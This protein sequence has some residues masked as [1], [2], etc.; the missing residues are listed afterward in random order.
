[1]TKSTILR[2]SGSKAKLLT[3]LTALAPTQFNRYVEPFAGSA[4]VFFALKPARAILGDLNSEVTDIYRAIQIDPIALSDALES[5]PKTR[6]SYYSIRAQD[7]SSLSLI[8][9][10]A[11]LIFLMKACFN[12]V[13]RKNKA[14][15]FN[16]PMGDK[17][18]A[19][20]SRDQLEN[21]NALLAGSNII[22][23]DFSETL[24][25]SEPGDWI[26]MDP[27]YPQNGRYRG[28]YGYAARFD[29]GALARLITEAKD[30]GKNG[31]L[32]S[33][34]YVDDAR[35]VQELEGWKIHRLSA[36]RSVSGEVSSRT[37][38]SEIVATNF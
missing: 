33:I 14:G 20:P 5:I 29:E 34:S 38:A 30:Y 7:P 2:W 36:R 13:Y 11:R 22:T 12:G 15:A 4:C 21:A 37:I 17:I 31:R 35:L 8:K 19:L 26:Y 25:R 23:G 3:K 27:P 9:R 24:S 6:E 28:E 18:Y 10:S 32:I 1:M 16:V